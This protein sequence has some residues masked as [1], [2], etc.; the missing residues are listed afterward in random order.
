LERHLPAVVFLQACDGG[1]LSSARGLTG[2]ASKV[3]QRNVPV[4]VAMQYPV[5]NA[6]A[7]AF[8]CQFYQ[9]LAAGDPVDQ[10]AQEGRR[11]LWYQYIGR[12][13]FATPVLFLR[14]REGRLFSDHFVDGEERGASDRSSAAAEIVSVYGSPSP[15]AVSPLS[16]LPL[17][18]MNYELGLDRM[19]ELIADQAPAMLGDFLV[20]EARMRE[21]LRASSLFGEDQTIR[22]ERA[23]VVASL[24]AVAQGVGVSFNDLCRG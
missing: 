10:A 19:R 17:G 14:V 24:N 12:R 4:V 5:S 1:T 20:L 16:S 8:A 13:E 15:T 2:V 18:G 3:V 22:S 6:A 11:V 7:L 23:R 9:R 21:N